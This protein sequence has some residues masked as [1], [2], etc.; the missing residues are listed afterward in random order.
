MCF[1]SIYQRLRDD[2]ESSTFFPVKRLESMFLLTFNF[3][4]PST[5]NDLSTFLSST[6][7]WDTLSGRVGGVRDGLEGRDVTVSLTT[8]G[9]ILS[10]SKS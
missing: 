5:G 3:L 1:S 6:E 4:N 9:E 2:G 8:S 10:F 7:E